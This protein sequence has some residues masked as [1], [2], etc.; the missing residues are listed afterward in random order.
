MVILPVGYIRADFN[1]D[2]K[3]GSARAND[4]PIA[5]NFNPNLFLPDQYMESS[6]LI[7]Y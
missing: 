3:P 7:V 4:K 5:K 6:P 1:S 2:E